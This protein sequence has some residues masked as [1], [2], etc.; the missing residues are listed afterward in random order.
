MIADMSGF[1]V[2]YLWPGSPEINKFMPMLLISLLTSLFLFYTREAL[3]IKRKSIRLFKL[4][5]IIIFIPLLLFI[6][7]FYFQTVDVL[8]P[9][10]LVVSPIVIYS[11]I[12]AIKNKLWAAKLFFV[13][14]LTNIVFVV[15]FIYFSMKGGGI[16]GFISSFDLVKVGFCSELFIFMIAT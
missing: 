6:P 5:Q 12:W 16:L 9:F 1:T 10:V 3:D 7:A 8:M 11:F 2:Q 4:Y 14:A 13:G 15:L